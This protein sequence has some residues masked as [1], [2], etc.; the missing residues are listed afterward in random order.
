MGV[1]IAWVIRGKAR[2]APAS[3]LLAVPGHARW[4]VL[5]A[6]AGQ[7]ARLQ[8]EAETE[9]FLD[10]LLGT[11]CYSRA[12]GMLE[13]ECRGMGQEAKA[14]LALQLA[15]C[16]VA[17]HGGAAPRCP[18]TG[19][20]KPCLDALGEREW[21]LYVEFLTHTDRHAGVGGGRGKVGGSLA[22][23]AWEVGCPWHTDAAYCAC[24][25]AQLVRWSTSSPQAW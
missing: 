11:D 7:L 2:T 17:T 23:M 1:V 6:C 5:A 24:R 12:V 10:R 4:P 15:A 19:P 8:G 22:G 21:Q 3:S 9:S 20:L 16:Q 18:S 25:T 14:R 13:G